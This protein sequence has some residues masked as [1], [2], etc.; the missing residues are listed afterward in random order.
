MAEEGA[1]EWPGQ[2]YALSEEG[3]QLPEGY[4]QLDWKRLTIT[5]FQLHYT[6][7]SYKVERRQL[8]SSTFQK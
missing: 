8:V 2:Q 5:V 7:G 3:I 6:R 1:G 4:A